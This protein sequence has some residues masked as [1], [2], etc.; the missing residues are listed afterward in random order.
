MIMKK[1]KK[2]T[3]ELELPAYLWSIPLR[4]TFNLLVFRCWI[5]LV[6]YASVLFPSDSHYCLPLKLCFF[7][8]DALI[9]RFTA[10]FT[11]HWSMTKLMYCS[12]LSKCPRKNLVVLGLVPFLVADPIVYSAKIQ[13]HHGCR[14]GQSRESSLALVTLFATPARA[15]AWA[16]YWNISS[17][18]LFRRCWSLATSSGVPFQCLS[19]F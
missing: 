13:R 3:V 15:E 1:K 5:C 18:W 16:R 17:I 12:D 10:D 2:R 8:V 6:Q 7:F 9:M 14:L 19:K 4:L 11:K